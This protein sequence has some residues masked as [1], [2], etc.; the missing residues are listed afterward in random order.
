MDE[1]ICCE[2]GAHLTEESEYVFEDKVMCADCFHAL[3]MVC[4]NCGDRIWND[5]AEGDDHIT[6]C[7]RCYENH[8]TT[9]DR[10]GRIIHQDYANE[11][12]SDRCKLHPRRMQTYYHPKSSRGKAIS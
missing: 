8:Y 6:L 11:T 12:R 2:C 9:C 5:D 7:Y 1:K 3:T 4:E 10:C